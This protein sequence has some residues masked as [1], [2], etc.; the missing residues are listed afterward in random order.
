M[1]AISLFHLS[2]YLNVRCNCLVD[3][4]LFLYFHSFSME[5]NRNMKWKPKQSSKAHT[6]M[7]HATDFYQRIENPTSLLTNTTWY[8]AVL[9]AVCVGGIACNRMRPRG[10]SVWFTYEIAVP[11][12]MHKSMALWC[13]WDN[14]PFQWLLSCHIEEMHFSLLFY[15]FSETFMC[16]T[17]L[18]QRSTFRLFFPC[19]NHMHNVYH[20][21]Y[22]R[23]RRRR[24]CRRRHRRSIIHQYGYNPFWFDNWHGPG[25]F[26]MNK[27]WNF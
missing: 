2:E 13:G 4:L 27:K 7:E 15:L 12:P 1:Y 19:A 26:T 9:N 10:A 25:H 22:C 23:R 5:L 17:R 11:F 8:N 21:C 20:C 18:R 6:W 24:C 16:F 3:A 14:W